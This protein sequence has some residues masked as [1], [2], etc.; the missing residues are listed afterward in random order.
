MKKFG[1]YCGAI[2]VAALAIPTAAQGQ[3][4]VKE[5]LTG[6]SP[7]TVRIEYSR[8]SKLRTVPNY[9]S[10]RQRFVG[11]RL[12]ALEESFAKLGVQED[13]IDEIVLGWRPGS[14]M[15]ELEGMVAGR[16]NV[17]EISN[18]ASAAGVSPTTIGGLPAFCLGTDSAAN[19]VVV[20]QNSLGAFG[21]QES[22]ASMLESRQGQAPGLATNERFAKLVNETRKDSPIWGVAIGDSVGDFFRAWMPTQGGLD[23]SRAF[24]SVEALTYN[25]N[26]GDR[27][28]LD[29]K[30]DCDSPQSAQSTRQ[31]FEGLKMFQQMAWQNTNPNKPNPFQAVEI[32]QDDQRVTL[33][34]TTN[35]ADLDAFALPGGA[36]N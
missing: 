23:W 4:L 35:Y 17:R 25:I 34:M 21:P 3:D 6:F 15:M 33:R 31:I 7:Q 10:L 5:S 1:V 2:V 29:A 27:V 19:C 16:F 11:P 32:S 22:V 24:Q 9:Q 18:R 30:L 26:T 20:I 12:R 28:S 36:G 13:D 14:S 8:L